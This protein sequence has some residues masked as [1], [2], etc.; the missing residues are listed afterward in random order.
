MNDNDIEVACMASSA[1]S[2]LAD[3]DIA[4]GNLR[5]YY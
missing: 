5:S 2:V 1:D 3:I 4:V